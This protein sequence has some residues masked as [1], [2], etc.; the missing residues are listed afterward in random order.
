MR[1]FLLKKP[2]ILPGF[3]ICFGL[4]ASYVCFLVL[5]PLAALGA[6]S[7]KGGIGEI[8]AVISDP[9]VLSALKFSFTA[10]FIAAAINSL[11]GFIIAWCLARYEFWGKSFISSLIDIPFALPTA[12]AGICLAYLFSHGGVM[13]AA[14]LRLGIDLQGADFTCVV[15]VLIF[16]GMP[17]VV[18]TTEPVIKDFD[19]QVLEAAE[20]LGANFWQIFRLIMLPSLLP[21]LITGFA[22]AFARGLGEYGSVIFISSNIPFKSEIL[23]VLIV[24]RLDSFNYQ[25]AAVI[26]FFMILVAFASLFLIN[27]IQKKVAK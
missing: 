27:F 6:F 3:N 18:R 24:S 9:R 13:G 26:G 15:I 25:E 17:F 19:K 12:V 4:G 20:N 22:L 21:S 2:S 10:S 1:K 5:L 11:F 7:F 8:L 23:P 16:V 14:L